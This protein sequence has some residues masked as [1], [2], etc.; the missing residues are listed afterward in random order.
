MRWPRAVIRRAA[1]KIKEG[2]KF[3]ISHEK[4]N[5]H[6]GRTPVGEVVGSFVKESAKGLQAIALGVLSDKAK[7]MDVCLD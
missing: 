4:D 6:E 3:F 1:E 5:S 2:A 7:D